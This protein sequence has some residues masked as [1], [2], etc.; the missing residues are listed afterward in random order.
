MTRELVNAE[1]RYE[2]FWREVKA[3]SNLW[4][5]AR[6]HQLAIWSDEEGFILPVWSQ[7]KYAQL[8]LSAFPNHEI[9]CY[10]LRAFI[11]EV[12]TELN[13]DD[14]MVGLNLDE[15]MGGVDVSCAEFQRLMD[16]GDA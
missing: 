4:A 3:S 1:E 15:T 6:G 9:R 16:R 13:R 10:P 7:E 2:N 12:L 5:L 11:E 14:I 8:G